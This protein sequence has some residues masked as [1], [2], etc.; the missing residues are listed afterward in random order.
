MDSFSE[1]IYIQNIQMG[2]D[3]DLREIQKRQ[4]NI[5]LVLKSRIHYNTGEDPDSICQRSWVINLK[6]K[7]WAMLW[8]ANGTYLPDYNLI[9]VHAG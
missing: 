2:E 4:R 3:L 8:P 7:S 5:F 6:K 9:E 1:S